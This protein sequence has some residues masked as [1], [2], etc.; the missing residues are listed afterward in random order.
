MLA[1]NTKFCL[2]MH[3]E[4]E[5]LE[6]ERTSLTR[7]SRGWSR[8]GRETSIFLKSIGLGIIVSTYQAIFRK[9][10]S[11]PKKVTIR[12]SRIT[13]FFTSLIHVIP[14]AI[15]LYEIV[16][17]LRG[18][19]VGEYFT[20]QAY[21]QLAAKAHEILIDASLSSIVLTYI[22]RE[23]TNGDGLPFGAFLA[24]LQFLSVS[25]LW[26][27]ELWSSTL[28]KSYGLRKSITFFFFIIVC[29]IIA[30]TAGPS[31]ATLLIPRQM[32]W[33]VEPSYVLLNGTFEEIWPDRLDPLQIPEE[34]ALLDQSDADPVCPGSDWQA[35][36]NELSQLTDYYG[37]AF[38][39][40]DSEEIATLDNYYFEIPGYQQTVKNG[41]INVCTVFEGNLQV[42]GDVVPLVV[43][44]AA[45]NDTILWK[46][47][48]GLQ[49]YA[50]IYHTIDQGFFQAYSAIQCV[51]D[52]AF[53]VNDSDPL[54]FP[55]LSRTLQEYESPTELISLTNLTKG[56]LYS[57]LGNFSEFRLLWTELPEFLFGSHVSGAIIL[58]PRSSAPGSPQN[59][60]ICSF[61]AGFGTSSAST[62]LTNLGE[63][64]SQPVNLP[65]SFAQLNAGADQ[66]VYGIDESFADPIFANISGF[67]Y[68]QRPLE[69]PLAWLSYLNPTISLQDGVNTTAINVYMSTLPDDISVTVVANVITYML[70]LGISSQGVD[71]PWQSGYFL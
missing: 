70:L 10:F 38:G 13:S 40:N 15:A 23:L 59:F 34:C 16:L 56:S 65:S 3:R 2:S 31:S 5:V 12:R 66:G 4:P 58:N 33:K 20:Q 21:Y 48:P 25:Y 44:T 69:L 47:P 18:R 51:P 27:R 39:D 7:V 50:D 54:Q 29:G 46:D 28:S 63:V 55:R 19:Y 71:I 68:P 42:C 61:G 43:V 52:M 37:A 35:I 26:S 24:S 57:T 11:E 9:G 67:N 32:R 6:W 30:A 62:D 36:Q 17:N 49:S 64:F 8:I 41:E 53:G 60:T 14:L 22:R 45:F 1:I